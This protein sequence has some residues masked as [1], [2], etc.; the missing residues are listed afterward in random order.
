MTNPLLKDVTMLVEKHG[1]KWNIIGE[2]LNESPEKL[3]SLYRREQRRP[4]D[5]EEI[6]NE[7]SIIFKDKKIAEKI[8]WRSLAKYANQGAALTERASHFQETADVYISTNTPIVLTFTGDW[9]LGDATVD[10]DEWLRHINTILD[11]PSVYMIDMGDDYQNM[12]SFKVLS[13][14]L[15]QVISPAQQAALMRSLVD[16]LTKKNKLIAKVGGNHDLEFDERIFGQAL[17]GYLYEN[18]KAPV[19]AN[20]GL[21]SLCVGEQNYKMLLFHKSRFR[22]I[23]RPTHGAYREWQLSY[24]AEIVAGAHDHQPG[25][26]IMWNYL[27]P[28]ENGENYGGEVFLIKIGTY[29]QGDYGFR[30]FHNSSINMPSVVLFP[31]V[32]KKILFTNLDDAIAFTRSEEIINE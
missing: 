6:L 31:D 12:R 7:Q 13:A 15:S 25:I 32:H 26:E 8:D 14:V 9:H 27:W 23:F 11:T 24:P 29:Q 22:S 2:I 17:Q 16:E 3:R 28:K 20:R 4:I 10:Y 30:Y 21:V 1:T 19:F 18:A 5:T